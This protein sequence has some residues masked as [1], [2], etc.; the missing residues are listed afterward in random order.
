MQRRQFIRRTGGIV[1]G[2]AVVGGAGGSVSAARNG[3]LVRAVQQAGTWNV[4]LPG[5]LDGFAL[6]HY[7]RS[8]TRP[9]SLESNVGGRAAARPRRG[10]IELSL[11]LTEDDPYGSPGFTV[12]TGHLSD[13]QEIRWAADGPLV[14]GLPLGIAYNGGT[15]ASWEPIAGNRE[16]WAGFDGDDRALAGPLAASDS[17]LGREQDGFTIPET[18]GACDDDRPAGDPCSGPGYSIAGLQ[19]EF[20]DVP[21]R[22]AGSIAGQSGASKTVQVDRFEVVET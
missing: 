6:E 15:I 19:E 8:A 20:G 10:G 14:I 11:D 3:Q 12:W 5:T 1:A 13:I 21:V 16:R 17:P 22:V 9:L 7:Y 2:S 18:G 4:I